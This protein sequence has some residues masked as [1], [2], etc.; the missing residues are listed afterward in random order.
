[1]IPSGNTAL[2]AMA[3]SGRH[4][5][6]FY[7]DPTPLAESVAFFA[8]SALE[9]GAPAV[10]IATPENT[11]RFL[12]AIEQ[13][14]VRID[15]AQE[16]GQ[17]VALDAAATLAQFMVDERP[18]WSRF[19]SCI[20]RVLGRTAAKGKGAIRAYGEMVNLL[21]QAGNTQGAIELEEFWNRL[22]PFYP[23]TLFCAYRLDPLVW[24]SY[25]SPLHEI[26]RTHTDVLATR[27]D[28]RLL[29]AVDA[30]SEAL[31][32]TSISRNLSY[33]G[34]EETVGEHRLPIGRRTLLWLHRHMPSSSTGMLERIRAYL[35]AHPEPERN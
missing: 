33:S 2:L 13:K 20:G 22:L 7:S 5:C 18:D 9:R 25:E 21:W 12:A 17:L 4:L 27:E 35:E 10:F 15:R 24:P 1:M 19:S 11:R 32:G 28:E 29:S 31:L 6:Q 16:A 14:G 3:P 8:G 30:A 23:V 26:G 34:C